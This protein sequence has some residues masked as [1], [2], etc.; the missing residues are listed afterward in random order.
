MKDLKRLAPYLKRYQGIIA[1]TLV[2]GVILGGI[3]LG[4]AQ[5]VKIIIDEVFTK[6]NAKVL[7]TAPL[8]IVG[9][10]FVGGII[11]FFHMY[12][13]RYTGEKIGFDIR[14]DLQSHYAQMSLDFH[15]A[16][17]PGALLSKTINDVISVQLGLSLLADV[18]REPL[19]AIAML[20][21]LFYIDWKLTLITFIAAPI[22]ILASRSLGRS[23]RKYSQMQQEIWENVTLVLKETLDGIR[24][25][26]AFGLELH[27]RGKFD[28]VINQMLAIRRQ[29]LKR[30]EVSGPLFELL[31]AITFSG[32]LYFAG[33]QAVTNHTTIGGFMSFVFVLGSLQ[34]PIKKLQD[35]H[36]RLQHTVAAS[37][38]IFEILD[39]PVT[40]KN[41]EER[42]AV[43]KKWTDDWKTI[44]FKN[45][46]FSYGSKEVLKGLD[47]TINRGEVVAIVG[48]SG[49]GKTTLVNLIPRF[50]DVTSGQVL[51][52]N[53]DVRDFRIDELRQHVGLVT[54]DVFLFN[55]TI[56][57]N[58]MAGDIADPATKVAKIDEALLAAN[59]G[60]VKKMKDQDL[61]IVGDR[62]TLLSGGERQRISIARAVYRNTPILILDE[63]TSSLDSES[64]KIVQDALERL[65]VG[66]T[67]FVIAHRL[68]TIQKADRIIVLADGKVVEEG[69]HT[70]LLEKQGAYFNFH[71]HQFG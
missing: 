41:P 8:M 13:L 7:R 57:E 63:A 21:Y 10:Y 49:G 37:K 47:L 44:Q 16:N 70:Q 43:A 34:G 22:L 26:K 69:R 29:I 67:T 48:S 62:G 45:V 46:R 17:S 35:A 9:I 24:V 58:I 4:T 32:I 23:V 18:V 36:V 33:Y 11:R 39:A 53:T 64:E 55:E 30:E 38:R 25:V 54:Q 51:I 50:Y 65:M 27:M 14:Q 59:A 5:M 12:Y 66:R 28:K 6:H 20:I 68:S 31:A 19:S 52:G 42:G 15:A 40:I 2:L 56:R 3:T 61:S 1:F 60:F 71:R